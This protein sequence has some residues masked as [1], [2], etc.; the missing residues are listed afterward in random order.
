MQ[1]RQY[2]DTQQIFFLIV[3]LIRIVRLKYSTAS[4]ACIISGLIVA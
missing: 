1:E 2:N 4:P 3:L